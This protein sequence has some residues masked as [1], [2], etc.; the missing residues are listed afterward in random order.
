MSSMSRTEM[1]H[2]NTTHAK[3]THVSNECPCW[4]WTIIS[5]SNSVDVYIADNVDVNINNN[6][7]SGSFAAHVNRKQ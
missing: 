2:F 5:K 7:I 6:D 1:T 4:S 3:F